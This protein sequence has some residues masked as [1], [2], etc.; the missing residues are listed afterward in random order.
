MDKTAKIKVVRRANYM[1]FMR[2]FKIYVDDKKMT[3]VGNGKEV[4]FELA[5][6]HHRIDILGSLWAKSEIIDIDLA[7]GET[8]RF[9]CGVEGKLLYPFFVIVFISILVRTF[10]RAMPG[11]TM[12]ALAVALAVMVYAIVMTV[13][14][15]KRG[16]V[17]YLKKSGS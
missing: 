15:F 10:L 7:P 6:G 1:G 12:I 9:E 11:G 14:T 17:Y 3:T 13:L 16:T 8:I 2:A 5:P 4:E